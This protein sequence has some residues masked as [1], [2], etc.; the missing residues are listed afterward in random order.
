MSRTV[1]HRRWIFN[2]DSSPDAIWRYVSNTERF[3]HEAGLPTIKAEEIPQPEGGSRRVI[4]QSLYGVELVYEEPQMEWVYAQ[5]FSRQALYHPS[6]L[7]PLSHFRMHAKLMPRP[8]GGSQLLY[9]V[10]FT[11][12]YR[13]A[14]PAIWVQMTIYER[15]FAR[16]FQQ[17]DQ[18]AKNPIPVYRPEQS[19]IT[20]R[21]KTRL[22][23]IRTQLI[24]QGQE[25]P[26]ID[27][28]FNH[29]TYA[30]DEEVTDIRPFA[31]ARKWG[32][33][34]YKIVE[35]FLRGTRVGLF[36]LS[37]AMLCPE[38]RGA[39]HKNSHLNGMMSQGRCLSCNIDF[40]TDF[41]QNIEATFTVHPSIRLSNQETLYCVGSPQRTP[42]ILMQQF[43]QPGEA[44]AITFTIKAGMY[45]V[46]VPTL[47]GRPSSP[48][49][50]ITPFITALGVAPLTVSPTAPAS[51]SPVLL[52]EEGE[53]VLLSNVLREGEITLSVSN[54]TDQVQF[55]RLV[56]MEWL[57][58]AVTAAEITSLQVFR[59]LFSDEALRPGESIQ[60]K[61]LTFLFTDLRGSTALYQTFGDAP[62]FRQVMDHFDVLRDQIDL[63][64][65]A[66][67]K[68]IGD[69]IMAVFTDPADA[70]T[71]A[72]NSL[73]AIQT[74]NNQNGAALVLKM[75]I[76]AGPCIAV[77][78]NE[79]LDYF[80]TTVNLAARLEGQSR[81]NDV[82]ISDT[83]AADPGVEELLRARAIQ[84]EPLSVSLKG[85]S[86]AI[87]IRRLQ[88]AE[89][90]AV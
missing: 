82:I 45:R 79:R 27:L 54:E 47:A 70:V 38:C 7:N 4:H 73:A 16:V 19:V 53:V 85:F 55:V 64:H 21:G 66:I 17:F 61:N 56:N 78:L 84:S 8:E 72:V 32:L 65:G 12:R 18:L 41:A 28:L 89:T 75:G 58:D 86:Q 3:N 87:P 50:A 24:Q 26:L 23:E 25:A 88:L 76:N 71:A 49:P 57:N 40:E 81:G 13:F 80:G 6:P 67:V 34:P 59:D 77:T 60:V 69:A 20:A 14:L 9:D 15:K 36:N 2:F 30:A 22:A 43:V 33:D 39:N 1:I 74:Y 44:R 42:H 46:F 10:W 68:T 31:L 51:K 48:K 63:Q 11:P 52:T 35:L 62:V 37:W 83:L 90:Q 29:L 5:Q